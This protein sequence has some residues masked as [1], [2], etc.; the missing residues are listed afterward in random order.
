MS[1]KD[2][3]AFSKSLFG[4]KKSDVNEF[5]R[6]ADENNSEKLKEKYITGGIVLPVI[7]LKQDF[8]PNAADMKIKGKQAKPKYTLTESARL[9]PERVRYIPYGQTDESPD[10]MW[11]LNGSEY[12][13]RPNTQVSGEI[14]L[15]QPE[16]DGGKI[17]SLPNQ[18]SSNP[19]GSI[20]SG[21]NKPQGKTTGSGNGVSIHS[22]SNS[23]NIQNSGIVKT[24]VSVR[25]P[26]DTPD[27]VYDENQDLQQVSQ[28][29]QEKIY[30]YNFTMMENNLSAKNDT[31]K[32][33]E[34]ALALD[35]IR[36]QTIK[37]YNNIIVNITNEKQIQDTDR[38]GIA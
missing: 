20:S 21:N 25:I 4:Y 33:L 6:T 24:P 13:S 7:R 23:I 29:I 5:I 22:S 37:N 27:E 30:G 17:Q 3:A 31:I 26:K 15:I 35:D 36:R 38:G 12:H 11:S 19:S 18:S 8:N 2:G 10:A 32:I 14:Q 16:Y 9:S 34:N 1:K 28:Y